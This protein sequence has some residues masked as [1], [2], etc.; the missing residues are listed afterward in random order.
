MTDITRQHNSTRK[1]TD[2]ADFRGSRSALLE[3]ATEGHRHPSHG[4]AR[5]GGWPRAF[6]ARAFLGRAR[7]RF[8]TDE[9][10][11][12]LR[13]G[14]QHAI[15]TENNGVR[16]VEILNEIGERA[17]IANNEPERKSRLSQPQ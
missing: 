8:G 10:S 12:A 7:L 9:P 16:G 17:V 1:N 6:R 14:L 11:I 4:R 13:E 5:P 15:V 3:R 2:E